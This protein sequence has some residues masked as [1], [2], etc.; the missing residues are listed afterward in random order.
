MRNIKADNIEFDI[1]K[2]D[3]SGF[4]KGSFKEFIIN[5]KSQ[6]I[7]SY[8]EEYIEKMYGQLKSLI[9][10]QYVIMDAFIESEKF[11]GNVDDK[12]ELG[13]KFGSMEAF[14]EAV[15][16]INTVKQYFLKLLEYMIDKRD[17]ISGRQYSFLLKKAKDFV[18]KNYMDPEISLNSVAEYIGLS[19]TYFSTV[20]K[21][22]AGMN[23]IDYL[24]KTRIDEAKRLLRSTDK[25]ISD[26]AMEVG[27]RD[28]H[29]FSSSF[30][31]YQGDTPKSY[32]ENKNEE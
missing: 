15:T 2:F 26:I 18:E 27:Y 20:F 6:D 4:N 25:R 5:G 1:K 30:K 21:Q 11:L 24:T 10:R 8:I 14:D 19:P 22:E 16:D 31:K 17:Q 12:E 3:T 13:N 23:F 7:E 28:Q 32:R 29:Y 9:F